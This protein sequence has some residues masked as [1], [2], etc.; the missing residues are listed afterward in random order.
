MVEKTTVTVEVDDR[1]RFTIPEPARCVLEIDDSVELDLEV[2]V[3]FP[4]DVE[5]SVAEPTVHVDDRGR[6]TI[7][8]AETRRDLGI[9]N[10]ESIVEATIERPTSNS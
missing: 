6:V 8:P 7:R 3:L 10:R 5:G 9:K 1:G 4:A 2:R